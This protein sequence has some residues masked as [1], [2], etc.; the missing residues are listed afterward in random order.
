MKDKN[1]KINDLLDKV[2]QE[3]KIERMEV[4]K[5]LQV[6]DDGIIAALEC[7][8]INSDDN[9]IDVTSDTLLALKPIMHPNWEQAYSK[10]QFVYAAKEANQGVTF[11]FYWNDGFLCWER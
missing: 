6:I 2:S 10:D 8:F 3:M 9:W 1:K 11:A 7:S 4:S 5:K